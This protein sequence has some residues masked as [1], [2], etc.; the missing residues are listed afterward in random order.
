MAAAVG[1]KVGLAAARMA[2]GGSLWTRVELTTRPWS[3]AHHQPMLGQLG[4]WAAGAMHSDCI[5][6]V[7]A[8]TPP[9]EPD[10][11]YPEPTNQQQDNI[12]G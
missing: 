11:G 4:S 2:G 3:A 6:T 1:R 7:I 10:D 8:L 5:I 12:D 9:Q